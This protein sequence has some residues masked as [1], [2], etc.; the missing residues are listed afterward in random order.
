MG[1]LLELVRRFRDAGRIDPTKCRA[2]NC[3]NELPDGA[4]HGMCSDECHT[5]YIIDTSI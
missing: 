5:Q 4:R 1:K 2:W 3:E